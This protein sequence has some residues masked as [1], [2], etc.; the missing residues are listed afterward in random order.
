[1]SRVGRLALD[2]AAEKVEVD[3][4]LKAL[5]V[6]AVAVASSEHGLPVMYIRY[7]VC[8]HH[9]GGGRSQAADG[10]PLHLQRTMGGNREAVEHL[11]IT[12]RVEGGIEGANGTSVGVCCLRAGPSSSPCQRC[13]YGWNIGA[14]QDLNLRLK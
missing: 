2:L 12:Q 3:E 7:V 11:P 13:R 10:E 14:P 4:A 8:I 6:V 5:V 9:S 1:M